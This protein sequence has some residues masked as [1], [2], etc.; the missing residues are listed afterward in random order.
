MLSGI[1]AFVFGNGGPAL[2]LVVALKEYGISVLG[3]FQ[4]KALKVGQLEFSQELEAL[5]VKCMT[6][7][8]DAE[9]I[10]L[11][12]ICVVI[13]YNKLIPKPLLKGLPAINIHMGLLPK[14]RGNNANAWAVLNGENKVG[15]SVHE[16]SDL[17]D[18][19]AIYYSFEYLING[20]LTYAPAK[21]AIERDI[22]LKVPALIKQIVMRQLAPKPQ[23]DSC[24]QYGIRLRPSDGI[25]LDWNITSDRVMRMNYVFGRPLGTGLKF[26]FRE[27]TYCIEHI[28]IV[29]NYMPSMGVPGS[30]VYHGGEEIWVK[31]GDT[32]VRLTKISLDG[33]LVDLNKEFKTGFRLQ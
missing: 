33:C 23:D 3:L 6:I 25:I 28:G 17:L 2:S 21:K 15:Y 31:T 19:G 9:L 4:D 16:V 20:D 5:D 24:F 29:S 14:Y 8:K 13:N 12:N 1:K 7:D 27:R 11:A 22:Q 26:Q 18:S 32:A 30:V 10:A